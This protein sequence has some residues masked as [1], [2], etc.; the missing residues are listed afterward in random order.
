MLWHLVARGASANGFGDIKKLLAKHMRIITYAEH[1]AF[2]DV[3]WYG[4]D[5][6]IRL[7]AIEYIASKCM[8]CDGSIS[9]QGSRM[10]LDMHPQGR[11]IMEMLG[12]YE[13]C[14][15]SRAFGKDVTD[16][17]LD[18]EKDFRLYG[19]AK[20]GW[21]LF[22][23]NFSRDQIVEKIDGQ[24]NV[25]TV[26]NPWPEPQ[27]FALEILRFPVYANPDAIILEDFSN[28]ALYSKIRSSDAGASINFSNTPYPV[29]YGNFSGVFQVDNKSENPA[30]C[31]VGKDFSS[32]VNLSKSRN[33]ALWVDGAGHGEILELKLLDKD[34]RAWTAEIKQDFTN[35]Q[36]FIFDI[37]NAKDID[38]SSIVRQTFTI[39]NIPPK[40]SAR[41]RMG[42]VKALPGVNPPA[43]SDMELLVNGKSIKFPGKLE[44][45][46][47]L[48]TDS[49]GH[50]TV[51]PGGMKAGKTFALPQSI[52]ELTPGPNK[53]EFRHK[54]GSQEGAGACVRL[55]PLRK[56]AETAPRK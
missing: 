16:M 4:L 32:A 31:M 17:M 18:K 56:V 20:T 15:V 40:T 23:A 6:A 29:Y 24:N 19:N 3:G 37:S 38:W 51:W 28:P 8:A 5:P 47:S 43:I 22:E 50:C 13:E 7:N 11:E 14:R 9:I 46:E 52:V 53:V 42:G 36:L 55:I 34:G 45:G 21:K 44:V 12:R 27:A 10:S 39:K 30:Q 41:C 25:W 2:A 1:F 26:E 35:W 48:T 54:V 49:L 33:I